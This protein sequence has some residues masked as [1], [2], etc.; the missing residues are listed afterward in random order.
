MIDLYGVN[1]CQDYLETVIA[2][3]L[4]L[5]IV[6]VT[7]Q[8]SWMWEIDERLTMIDSA[9][10]VQVSITSQDQPARQEIHLG[11]SEDGS[12]MWFTDCGD[13]LP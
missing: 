6:A 1:A 9:F 10:T 12:I 13:P 8:G 5:E 11:I 7:G 4:Q 2:N 3:P